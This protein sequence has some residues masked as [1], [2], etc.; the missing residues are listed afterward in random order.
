M[1]ECT[2]HL[3]DG[4]PVDLHLDD[5]THPLSAYVLLAAIPSDP[6]ASILLTHGNSDVVGRLMMTLYERSVVEHPELAWML[7]QVSRGII[8]LVDA[9]RQE[10]PGDGTTGNA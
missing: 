3:Q 4:H 9:A 8:G 6:P 1:K 5:A 7:E 2:I 10:W